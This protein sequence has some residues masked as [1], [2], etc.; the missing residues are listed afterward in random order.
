M[1]TPRMTPSYKHAPPHTQSRFYVQ[2]RNLLVFDQSHL[3]FI[4]W[5]IVVF[6]NGSPS[7]VIDPTFHV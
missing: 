2:M 3:L 5:E 1:Y 6:G 4:L 7:T